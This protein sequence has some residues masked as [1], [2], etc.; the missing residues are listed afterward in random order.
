MKEKIEVHRV[1]FNR[2]MSDGFY[3]HNPM[4]KASFGA[5]TKLL[6]DQHPAPVS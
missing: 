3:T 2:F 1:C 4:A 5:G 6:N